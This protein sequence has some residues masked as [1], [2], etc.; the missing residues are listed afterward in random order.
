MYKVGDRVWYAQF[1]NRTVEVQCP[2]DLGGT[3]QSSGVL[4]LT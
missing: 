3:R 4:D 1:E 2:V